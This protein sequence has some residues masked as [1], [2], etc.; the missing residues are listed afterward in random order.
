MS[1]SSFLY[2]I[3]N[4]NDSKI[5]LFFS[6]PKLAYFIEIKS[7]TELEKTDVMEALKEMKIVTETEGTYQV[8]SKSVLVRGT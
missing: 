4:R 7:R 6:K 8:K 3:A 2:F 5:I 1:I